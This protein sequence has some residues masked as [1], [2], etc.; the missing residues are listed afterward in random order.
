MINLFSSSR[1]LA[2][3]EPSKDSTAV[4]LI[5]DNTSEGRTLENTATTAKVSSLQPNI[6]INL[7]NEVGSPL[8]PVESP[9]NNELES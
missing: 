2:E 6:V 8:K 9:K 7:T 3:R 1:E 5:E 4:K